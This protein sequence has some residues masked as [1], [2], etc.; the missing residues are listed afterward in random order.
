[1]E[2]DY[3]TITTERVEWMSGNGTPLAVEFRLVEEVQSYAGNVVAKKYSIQTHSWLN[4]TEQH[5][6]W[7]QPRK[8]GQMVAC[9]GKIGLMADRYEILKAAQDKVAQH[10]LY[11]TQK[12]AEEAAIADEAAT[13]AYSNKIERLAERGF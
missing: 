3:N 4:G 8:Q 6:C 5:G 7:M 10:P 2:Y 12:A 11:Q 9:I 1:M 13:I